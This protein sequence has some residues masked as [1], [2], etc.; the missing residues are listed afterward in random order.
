MK[1][2]WTVRRQI[3]TQEQAQRRWD[4]GYR[5]LVQ[6]ASTTTMS[7]QPEA[8]HANCSVR[9]GLDHSASPSANH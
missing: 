1:H 9:A 3:T 6:W 7:P 8:E 4:Q 5:L 2:L